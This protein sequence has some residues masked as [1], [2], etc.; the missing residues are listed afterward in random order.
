[1]NKKLKKG[2]FEDLAQNLRFRTILAKDKV[3]EYGDFGDEFFIILKGIVRIEIPDKK[4]KNWAVQRSDY[5]RLL[6]WK[7]KDFNIRAL[8][9][10]T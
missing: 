1:M 2:E 4:I 7:E 10:Q 6:E 8:V 3:M 9:A 5:K